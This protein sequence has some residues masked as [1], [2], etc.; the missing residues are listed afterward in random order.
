[1][2][3]ET[4]KEDLVKQA[5]AKADK[6][7]LRRLAD[8]ASQLGFDSP[9]ITILKRYPSSRTTREDDQQ[10]RPLLVTTG[11]GLAKAQRCG[12]P[13]SRAFEEDR[14]FLSIHHLHDE[15]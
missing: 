7:V 3:R 6:V 12:K 4:V 10:S 13:H 15:R 8:L 9:E 14:N 2:P 11:P 1:M 5:T